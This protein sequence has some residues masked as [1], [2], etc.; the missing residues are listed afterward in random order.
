VYP[1]KE[2]VQQ[3]GIQPGKSEDTAK[4]GDSQRKVRRIFKM[5]REV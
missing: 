1:I 3:G 2:N 5:L 4:E